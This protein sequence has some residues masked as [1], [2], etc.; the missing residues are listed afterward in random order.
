MDSSRSSHVRVLI[1]AAVAA[2]LGPGARILGIAEW[3]RQGRA[4]EQRSHQT[5]RNRGGVR[6][7]AR[8]D[9]GAKRR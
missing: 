1:A 4:V 5:R 3:I 6:T 7:L 9:P 2:L 8:T